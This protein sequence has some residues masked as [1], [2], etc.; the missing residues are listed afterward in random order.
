MLILKTDLEIFEFQ[1]FKIFLET[2]NI[3]KINFDFNQKFK[4]FIAK[5]DK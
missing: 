5:N 4:N 2:L 3:G 1:L